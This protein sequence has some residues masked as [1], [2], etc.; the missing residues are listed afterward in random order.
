MHAL[1]VRSV[2][3]DLSDLVHGARNCAKKLWE[4]IK[5]C[6]LELWNIVFF[7]V[8][9]LGWTV[10]VSACLVVSATMCVYDLGHKKL[11]SRKK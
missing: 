1:K 2:L 9:V 11:W 6:I 3:S 4:S 8:G 5:K 7:A 10:G